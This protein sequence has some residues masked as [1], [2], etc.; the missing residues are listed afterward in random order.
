MAE[1]GR[2]LGIT[3]MAVRQH[4]AV[5]ERDGLVRVA[6]RRG[7]TGRP[8]HVYFLTADGQEAFGQAYDAF[9]IEILRAAERVGGR[10]L[11]DRLFA[12]REQEM[13]ERLVRQLGAEQGERRLRRLIEAERE[14]GYRGEL[15]VEGERFD[16]LQFNCPIA[17]VAVEYPEACVHDHAMY[18]RLLATRLERS[19]CAAQ[20]DG[21]CVYRGQVAEV[22]QHPAL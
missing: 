19:G 14:G 12:E 3:P 15:R 21:P 7:S 1:V 20:G 13:T 9:A 17:K 4:L 18:E 11:V 16:F 22:I 6:R 2:Q 10:S 5:L 8:A